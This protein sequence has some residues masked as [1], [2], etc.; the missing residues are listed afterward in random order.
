MVVGPP[1]SQPFPALLRVASP[2][3]M[4]QTPTHHGPNGEG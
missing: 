2:V 3:V 1:Q 4:P